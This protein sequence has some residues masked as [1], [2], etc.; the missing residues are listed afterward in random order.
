MIT[1]SAEDSFLLGDKL[2]QVV[3]R[4]SERIEA[5]PV[6]RMLRNEIIGNPKMQGQRCTM[7]IVGH[8]N[9]AVL[10][11]VGFLCEV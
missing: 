11:F 7:S 1:A 5:V 4:G 10:I 2:V 9:Q 6:R 3:F 8:T